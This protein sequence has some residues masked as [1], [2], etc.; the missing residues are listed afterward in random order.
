MA[1]IELKNVYKNYGDE[2]IEIKALKKVNFDIE[3]G[4]LIVI[5]G[6]SGTGKTT[7]LNILGGID[8]ATSGNVFVNG[9]DISELKERKLTKYRREDVG[10]VFQFYNLIKNLTVK[11]NVELATQVCK[12]KTDSLAIIKKVGLSKK[13]DN[14]PSELSVSEQQRVSIA[15]AI[16]KKPRVLLCDEPIEALDEKHG[17][18]ILKLLQNIAKKE[19]ITIIITTHNDAIAPMANKVITFKN[20]TVNNVK[21]NKKPKLAGDLE[22]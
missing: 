22:W 21:I 8:R 10:F 5:V 17:K 4:E 2:E 16:A 1:Y 7:C 11:E 13:I 20:G 9:V 14:F 6:P 19:H 12:D 15:R 18:Q 3:K